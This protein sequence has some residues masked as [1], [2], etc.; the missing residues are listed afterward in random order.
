[1]GRSRPPEPGSGSIP[2]WRATH[3]HHQPRVVIVIFDLD[4]TVW[5][6]I[7]GIA[8]SLEH[9]FESLDLPVPSRA[10]LTTNLGPP[11][12]LMLAELGVP[13][14]MIDAATLRYRERYVSWGAYQATIYPGIERL[15]ADLAEAGHRL[16]TATSKGE[17]PTRQMLDHFGLIDRFE[18]VG[19]ATMDASAITKPAVVARTLEGLGRPDPAACVMVGDRHYDVSGSAEHGIGCVGVT[20]GY[21]DAEELRT[22]GAEAIIDRPAELLE[23]VRRRVSP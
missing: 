12:Q 19:A 18:V 17:G 6:S 22:A 16:A 11:L 21:G 9:T 13:E 20:W 2:G 5:D 8:G 14:A 4:G 15:L 7:E 10:E 3:A 1:M 23:V